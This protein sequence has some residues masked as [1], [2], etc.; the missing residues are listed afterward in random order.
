MA[1]K[2]KQKINKLLKKRRCD[3]SILYKRYILLSYLEIGGLLSDIN[4]GC[5]EWQD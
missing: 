3:T 2:I 1:I 4:D 5:F